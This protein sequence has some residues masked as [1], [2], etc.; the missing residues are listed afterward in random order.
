M[1]S[2]APFSS[3]EDAGFIHSS[4]F[5]YTR[6]TTLTRPKKKH[7]FVVDLSQWF[8]AFT[9]HHH[10]E[11]YNDM[12]GRIFC[13]FPLKILSWYFTQ[14]KLQN[15]CFNR[16]SWQHFVCRQQLFINVISRSKSHSQANVKS[17]VIP[18]AQTQPTSV[19]LW[20]ETLYGYRHFLLVT[21]PAV[22]RL[23]GKGH[24]SLLLLIN[25]HNTD[26][27]HCNT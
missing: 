16:H 3:S 13:C 14:Y 4:R 25:S 8:S 21:V 11:D 19:C 24:F 10:L 27:Q 17:S 5:W 9:V 6:N 12:M 22:G 7:V 26:L 1:K 15:P 2:W 18:Q 20:P 23:R